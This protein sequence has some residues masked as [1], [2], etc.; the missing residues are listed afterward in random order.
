MKSDEE[1]IY[2]TYEYINKP[3][4]QIILGRILDKYPIEK[5]DCCVDINDSLN[6]LEYARAVVNNSD[7]FKKYIRLVLIEAHEIGGLEDNTFR[8]SILVTFIDGV[9]IR[10]FIK[11]YMDI[12]SLITI[13]KSKIEKYIEEHSYLDEY[14][15]NNMIHISYICDLY[16]DKRYK[17]GVCRLLT[18]TFLSI[19]EAIER[20]N[21][22]YIHH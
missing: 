6:I 11:N 1:I 22:F 20:Y 18:G 8:I 16:H 3:E 9:S 13:F 12:I 2:K 21:V 15:G 17:N 19:E 7:V 10:Y 5:K 4:T 14:I